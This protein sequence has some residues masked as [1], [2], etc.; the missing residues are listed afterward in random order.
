M[1][2]TTG[3]A[4][5]GFRGAVSRPSLADAVPTERGRAIIPAGGVSPVGVCIS[6]VK[7]FIVELRFVDKV[8]VRLTPFKKECICIPPPLTT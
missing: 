6:S 4:E 7:A 3:S 1:V 8:P 5:A 2:G